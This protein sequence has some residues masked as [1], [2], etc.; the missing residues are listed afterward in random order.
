METPTSEYEEARLDL[1][2][3]IDKN[4]YDLIT[5]LLQQQTGTNLDTQVIYISI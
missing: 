4:K 1:S 5:R 3:A 2:E